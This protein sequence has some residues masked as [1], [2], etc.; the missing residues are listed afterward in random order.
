MTV[1]PNTATNDM[2]SKIS[3]KAIIAS[4]IREIGASRRLKKPLVKPITIPI[5][6]EITATPIPT[7]KETLPA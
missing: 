2:A 6:E 1:P 3:G 4:V 7:I 5:Q